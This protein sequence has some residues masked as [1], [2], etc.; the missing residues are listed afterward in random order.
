MLQFFIC[1]SWR[2]SQVPPAPPYCDKCH[3]FFKASPKCPP[4]PA[5]IMS[6]SSVSRDVSW[7]GPFC[8]T[9]DTDMEWTGGQWWR[10]DQFIALIVTLTITQSLMMNLISFSQTHGNSFRWLT[11]MRDE[12]DDDCFARPWR[13]LELFEYFHS[14]QQTGGDNCCDKKML[15]C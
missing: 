14:P 2:P 15:S 3:H 6:D 13:T 1:R 8:V 5:E 4:A 12:D 7:Q 11:M 10:T 9:G